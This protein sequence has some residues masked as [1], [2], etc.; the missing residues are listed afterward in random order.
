[1]YLCKYSSIFLKIGIYLQNC[2]KNIFIIF[3][4]YFR[5]FG[6]F[7]AFC[8]SFSV[9]LSVFYRSFC[10]IFSFSITNSISIIIGKSRGIPYYFTFGYL[11]GLIGRDLDFYRSAIFL[12]SPKTPFL[13][14]LL[15]QG[16]KYNF[17]KVQG[18]RINSFCGLSVITKNI[19]AI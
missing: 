19:R 7:L 3:L 18:L 6:Q 17:L 13:L 2:I 10:C 11:L 14:I 1:M 12:D 9:F 8:K 4:K 5:S 16:S 15:V